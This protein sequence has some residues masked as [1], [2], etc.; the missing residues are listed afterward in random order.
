[1]DDL[2]NA[3]KENLEYYKN[4]EK[5]IIGILSTLPKGR[6]K[7]KKINGDSYYYLQYRKGK[8][9][10]DKYVGKNYP[11]DIA[12]KIEQRKKLEDQLKEVRKA[13]KLLSKNNKENDVN[14]IEPAKK[15]FEKL[16][17]EKLWE[18]GFEIIG[19]W[20]FILY[21]KYLDFP[22]YPLKTDDLDILIPLPYKGKIFDIS[23]FFKSLGFSENFNPD[24]SI[25]YT[26]PNLKVEF[27]SPEK[28]KKEFANYIKELR[29]YPQQLRYLEILLSDPIILKIGRGIKVKVPSPSSF[30]LHKLLIAGKRREK[31][32][33]EKDIKQA[34]Y[35]GKYILINEKEKLV[36]MFGKLP[37]ARK[38]KILNALKKSENLFILEQETIRELIKILSS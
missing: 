5:I 20:C 6:I 2:K 10:I 12:K 30:F 9:I 27:L 22:K 35:T 7:E 3:L 37:K 34:I 16:S 11:K 13:I 8:K 21:Q 15:I 28:R 25:F 33:G 32:K 26:L 1:M 4:Q 18:E 19:S 17:K 38:S 14:L 31:G 23:S 36:G 29:I 24:G